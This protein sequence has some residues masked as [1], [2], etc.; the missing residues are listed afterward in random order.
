MKLFIWGL[1]LLVIFI[2]GMLVNI[3]GG[4]FMFL[5]AAVILLAIGAMKLAR[6]AG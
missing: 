2:L 6:P 1:A 4:I 5:W 3:G